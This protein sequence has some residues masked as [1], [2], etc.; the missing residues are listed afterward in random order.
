MF[1][2]WEVSMGVVLGTPYL[3]Q[4]SLCVAFDEGV[5]FVGPQ[6]HV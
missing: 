5:D 4:L 2:E 1:A 6:T 3:F